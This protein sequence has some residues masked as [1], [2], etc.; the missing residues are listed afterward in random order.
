MRRKLSLLLLTTLLLLFNVAAQDDKTY[1][2]DRFDVAVMAESDRSLLVEETVTFRFVGGPFSFVFR[3]LPTDHTDGI[4]DIVAGVDGVPWPQGTGPGQVEIS[5]RNPIR[6]EWHLSPTADTA[7]TFT[8]SYRA[9]GVVRRVVDNADQADVLDWQALPDEYEYT[10]DNSR[11]TIQ[12]PPQA[13]LVGQP[14]LLTGGGE[15]SAVSQFNNTAVFEA[16]NLEPGDPLVARLTFAPGAFA[17]EPPL[18]QGRQEAQDSRAWIWLTAAGATLLGGLLAVFAAARPYQNATRKATSFLHKPPYDLP[19]ALVGWLFNQTVSWQ[20]GLATLFDLAGRGHVAIDESADKK[21]YRSSEFLITLLS[22]PT[23]P[24]PHEQALL[25]ILFTDRSGAP[26]ESITMSSMGQLIT[27]SR[28]KQF[29]ESVKDEAE[30]AGWLSEAAKRGGNRLMVWGI[31]LMVLLAPLG[32]LMFVLQASFGWWPLVLIGALF[33]VSIFAFVGSATVSPL[34]ERGAQQA[35]AYDPFRR[36]I[37]QAAKGK[38]DVPDPAYYEA[39]LPFAAAFGAAEAWVKAQAKRGYDA[40]P[41]YFRALSTDD[42]SAMMVVYIAAISAA[43]HSGGS[44][45]AS[46]GAAGAAAAGGGASGAG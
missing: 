13:T 37:D 44:A 28:W 30:A 12:Y 17:G 18:W 19:P 22:R 16:R 26:Q 24:R 10:I 7:Q 29:T 43:S 21:W 5:G 20:H 34:S 32:A 31:V 27:S 9:L 8:L 46:A 2:A 23:N 14:E 11:V 33:L 3:E 25:D 45:A 39:Y 6:V 40:V 38:L 41:A 1:S 4:T 15:A 36:F 35:S 42:G